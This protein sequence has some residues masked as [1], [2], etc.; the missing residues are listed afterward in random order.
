MNIEL[1]IIQNFAPSNLNR[2]DTNN[3]KDCTFGGV[4][5]ARISSQAFKRAIRREPIFADSTGVAS[6]VR[7][8]L[9]ATTRFQP[10]LEASG[11]SVE[12]A[13]RVAT[14]L[15][16]AIGNKV[17]GDDR[18]TSV[19]LYLSEQEVDELVNHALEQW[20]A[21]Q[22]GLAKE[23]PDRKPLND[24]VKDYVKQLRG[25]ASAPDIAM[26]GRM[27]AEHPDFN[28]DAACQV[29]H[30]ISTHQVS[31]DM[32]FFT[33]V[34]DLQPGGETGSAHMG[35]TGFNS[36]TFYRYARIDWGQLVSNLS[37]DVHL[38]HRTVAGFLRAAVR[39]IPTGK[40]NTFAAHNPPSFLMT[41]VRDDGMSWSLANAFEKPVYPGYQRGLIAE[42]VCQ[43]DAYWGRLDQVYG[44]GYKQVTV[45]ALDPDLPLEHLAGHAVGDVEA[46]V[47]S[48]LDALSSVEAYQP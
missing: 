43:L 35:M 36:A 5:R 34:D 45:L 30:A 19:L 16:E 21:I 41:V 1:H 7:T 46:W 3:P 6:A 4:R 48:T 24:L 40:Q 44:T 15:A 31:M 33:A 42:S 39:A 13:E 14:A 20:D 9:L 38:A 8:R 2:D 10:K 27:L 37:G 12:D 18:H 29:A 17:E 22:A 23:K 47:A 26:F 25:R 11:A 28:I 32:D